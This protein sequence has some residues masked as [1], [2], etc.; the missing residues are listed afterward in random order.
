MVVIGG[1]QSTASDV[2]DMASYEKSGQGWSS[3]PGLDDQIFGSS[4]IEMD[5]S[6]V[7]VGGWMPSNLLSSAMFSLVRI[8]M[9]KL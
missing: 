2:L 7:L 6:L 8:R 5:N 1:M 3:G 4:I 9:V